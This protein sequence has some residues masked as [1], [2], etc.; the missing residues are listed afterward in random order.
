VNVDGGG[1]LESGTATASQRQSEGTYLV[2]F[3]RD[4]SSCAAVASA[5]TTQGGET[6]LN[7]DGVTRVGRNPSAT[8]Q[9]E[10]EFVKPD[11][12]TPQKVSGSRP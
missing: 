1:V 5:G 4:V 6:Q 9:V 12:T 8:N 7:A 2:S 10:V 11:P 3:A